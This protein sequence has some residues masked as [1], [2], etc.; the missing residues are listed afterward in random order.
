MI[1]SMRNRFQRGGY[2]FLA[3]YL[4]LGVPDNSVRVHGKSRGRTRAGWNAT[5]TVRVSRLLVLPAA[6]FA[7]PFTLPSI[8]PPP[9]PDL[10]GSHTPARSPENMDRPWQYCRWNHPVSSV[11]IYA[12]AFHIFHCFQ[13]FGSIC[14]IKFVMRPTAP[15]RFVTPSTPIQPLCAHNQRVDA[16]ARPANFHR[17]LAISQIFSHP[18]RSSE[19]DRDRFVGWIL[20]VSNSI[21][22]LVSLS[23]ETNANATPCVIKTRHWRFE[24]S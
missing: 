15:R 5:G 9:P 6:C 13:V 20:F 8:S 21:K 3:T 14:K 10:A 12:A 18:R 1:S 22:F 7:F 16:Y 11:M 23:T 17:A 4:D 24:F 2:K 19:K